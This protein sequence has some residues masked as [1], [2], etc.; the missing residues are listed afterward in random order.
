MTKHTF[1]LANLEQTK[2]LAKVIAKIVKPS[3]VILL[4]GDLGVGK[5]TFAQFFIRYIC[6]QQE[7]VTSPTFNLV[8]NYKS[9]L[10][11]IWHFDLYR[12]NKVEEVFEL[13]LEDALKYGVTLIEWPEIIEKQ[14]TI[15]NK[16][17]I[18][19]KNFY[20]NNNRIVEVVSE[21]D[22]QDISIT[23]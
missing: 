21:G 2:N 18:Q 9:T 22:L 20:S 1:N 16:I 14:L 15:P 6:G 4:K 13:G 7:E 12:V 3:S 23:E 5:T 19:F 10:F 17:T 8:H 11:D